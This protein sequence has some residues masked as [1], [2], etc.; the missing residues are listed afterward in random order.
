MSGSVPD[1]EDVVQ[2]GLFQAYRKLD[3]FDEGPR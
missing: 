1:G 3:T 2:E